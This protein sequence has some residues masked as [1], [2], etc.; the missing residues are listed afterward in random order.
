[1]TACPRFIAFEGGEG[2][3]KSTQIRLLAARL[4]QI[5]YQVTLTR[6]PGGTPQGAALRK[7]LL[8]REAYP[9]TAAAE[10]LLMVADRA[11]HLAHVIEPALRDGGVVLTD[12]FVF[13][14]LAYQGAGR[15]VDAHILRR[16][17]AQFCG[18]R[19]PDLTIVLDIAPE[20]GLAR[21]DRRH[22][23]AGSD[24][25][26]F[27]ALDIDFHRRVRRAFL[28]ISAATPNAIVV[29]ATADPETVAAEI[30]RR[31]LG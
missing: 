17:H 23:S 13:S 20:V 30:A 9:W 3:G 10:T 2:A 1:M 21:S 4:E 16:L 7:L 5:G 29:D 25:T 8:T 18:D 19:W 26:R 12:R 11:E 22:I 27:E 31:V 28:D 6:E 14:T 24:E 15:G